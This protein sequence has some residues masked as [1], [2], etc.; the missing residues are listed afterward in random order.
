MLRDGQRRAVERGS[1]GRRSGL[2]GAHG[3]CWRRQVEGGCEGA[4]RR[5]GGGGG[6]EGG[7]EC[8]RLPLQ[9]LQGG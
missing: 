3:W 1:S 9:A 2:Q 5:G 4:R 8:V 7:G 6:E